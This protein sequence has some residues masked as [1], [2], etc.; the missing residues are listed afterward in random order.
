MDAAEIRELARA[1]LTPKQFDA[2][3]L[4]VWDG[5]S[6]RKVARILGIDRASLDARLQGGERRL[7]EAMREAG[8]LEAV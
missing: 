7:F 3:R 8:A 5:M 6:K 4:V 2:W 1:E